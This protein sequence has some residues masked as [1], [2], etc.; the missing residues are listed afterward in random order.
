MKNR[1]ELSET[2][3]KLHTET[4]KI[5]WQELLRFFAGGYTIEVQAPANLIE[6]AGY[7]VEDRASEIQTLMDQQIV[8]PVPDSKA[9]Q[10]LDNDEEV[11]AVVLAPWVLVQGLPN[12]P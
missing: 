5:K 12:N 1:I 4:A 3:A 10:W 11:W 7:F 6:V 2:Q 9:K 8:R